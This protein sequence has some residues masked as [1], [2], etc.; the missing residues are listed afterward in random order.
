MQ[1]L[2]NPDIIEPEEL[3]DLFLEYFKDISDIFKVVIESGIEPNAVMAGGLTVVDHMVS[4]FL[5]EV[6]LMDMK[7]VHSFVQDAKR[8]KPPRRLSRKTIY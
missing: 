1:W 2:L 6:S 3:M 4:Y 8:I 7:D 5:N